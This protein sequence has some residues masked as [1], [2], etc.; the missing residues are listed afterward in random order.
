MKPC[1]L[2]PIFDH[3][4]T[5]GAVVEA[6]A[7]FGLPVLVVDDGSGPETRAELARLRERF[8]DVELIHHP[9]NQGRGA[10][11]RT[12]Y[13]AALARGFSHA[14]Q[15]DAD[16]QH[17]AGDLPRFLEAARANPDALV[18]GV[19]VFDESAPWLRLQGRKLSQGIV[20]LETLS[21]AVRDPLCGFRCLPL[22]PTCAALESTRT[23]DRMDFD[24]EIVVRLVRSGVPV[25][26]VPTTIRYF[27]DGVSH[28]RMVEDNLRIAW[29]YLRLAGEALWPRRRARPWKR[30]A[31]GWELRSERGSRVALTFA[32][33]FFRRFGRRW[34]VLLLHP[35]V[36]YF[37]LSS[38]TVRRASRRYLTALARHRDGEAARP[39]RWTDSY[40][41]I[42]AF[43][44]AILDRLCL[45]AGRY[46][47]FDVT[48]HGSE[49]VA[50]YL[51][52]GRGAILVGAHLGCFDLLRVVARD[53]QVP[54]TAVMFTAN[55]RGINDVFEE[56]DPSSNLRILEVEPGSLGVA[57]EIRQRLARGE[58]VALLADRVIPGGRDR[59]A[60]A[61]F[62][63]RPASFPAGPFRLPTLLEVPVV[64]SLALKT[65]PARYEVFFES[66]ADG[67]PIPSD[68]RD[69]AVQQRVELF[70]SRLEHY[71][72][73]APY[74][75]FNFYDY[76]SQPEDPE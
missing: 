67:E 31:E 68:V 45:W 48:I 9:R 21:F 11:L 20:W 36:A 30:D 62:L 56:L 75:W 8:P 37:F 43:G 15:L 12:G 39:V 35:S 74:Q 52:R 51:E 60:R 32:V 63:G 55:A 6:V 65:G 18:L 50:D 1:V 28:F 64:L 34:T 5:I 58:L 14:V 24:P 66:L 4:R 53:A 57:F 41:H 40:R 69:K 7:G 23:G 54:V 73:R 22:A 38:G 10:A 61:S 2:I 44:D 17:D 70:A 33:R 72:L 25:V 29:A 46:Q 26:S 49:V 59:I 27:A 3:G 47:D 19:P 71:C 76:W 13:R 16:G 42:L